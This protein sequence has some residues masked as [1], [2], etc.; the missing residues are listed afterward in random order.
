MFKPRSED[1]FARAPAYF[2]S[3]WTLEEAYT[4][5]C[6]LM[7]NEKVETNGV[8]KQAEFE[9]YKEIYVEKHG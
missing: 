2:D 1:L 9:L 3:F 6:T 5:R 8:N 4:V 7:R